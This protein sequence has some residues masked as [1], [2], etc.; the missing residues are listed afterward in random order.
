M[1]TGS[2]EVAHSVVRTLQL[3]RPGLPRNGPIDG[4]GVEMMNERSRK[5]TNPDNP[6]IVE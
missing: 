3:Q 2:L 1:A 5:G 4:L 6:G